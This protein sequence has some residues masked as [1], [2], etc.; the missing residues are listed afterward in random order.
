VTHMRL[1]ELA[2]KYYENFTFIDNGNV[3]AVQEG[4]LHS[5]FIFD[6]KHSWMMTSN[7]TV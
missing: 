2:Y 6:I 5:Q 4:R 7:R 3:F 1:E